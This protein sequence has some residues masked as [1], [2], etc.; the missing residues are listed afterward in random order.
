MSSEFKQNLEKYAN[1][2][3]KV[4]LNLQKGQRL[5]IG[6]PFSGMNGVSV[7]VT[8]LVR[9]IV[10]KAYQEGAKLV[11]IMWDDD[12]VRMR[13]YSLWLEIQMYSLK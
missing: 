11:D 3:V 13:C 5:L 7:E 8:P 12:Q 6:A 1:I 2:I 10:K 9:L 4:G